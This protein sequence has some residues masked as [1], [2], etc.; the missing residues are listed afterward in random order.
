VR[1]WT[2][3]RNDTRTAKGALFANCPCLVVYAQTLKEADKQ[4]EAL[5]GLKIASLVHIGVRSIDAPHAGIK[6]ANT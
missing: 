3:W 4:F 6:G 2:Y 5:S 1:Q